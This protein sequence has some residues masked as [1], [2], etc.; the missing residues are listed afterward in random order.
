MIAHLPIALVVL[1][2]LVVLFALVVVALW[3]R[4]TRQPVQIY[5][6]TDERSMSTD[7]RGGAVLTRGQSTPAPRLT[8]TRDSV[9]WTAAPPL[10]FRILRQFGVEC[11]SYTYRKR[12]T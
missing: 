2:V 6:A 11:R 7:L 12:W 9:V 4:T 1:F 8:E 10:H 5:V 3:M